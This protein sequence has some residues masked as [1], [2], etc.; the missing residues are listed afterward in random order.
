MPAIGNQER[1]LF[2]SLRDASRYAASVVNQASTPMILRVENSLFV[3]HDNRIFVFESPIENTA[4]DRNSSTST[5]EQTLI[6][7]ILTTARFR[8]LCYIYVTFRLF[9]VTA[10]AAI[11]VLLILTGEFQMPSSSDLA[12]ISTIGLEAF[13][14][15][16]LNTNKYWPLQRLSVYIGLLL[17][18]MYYVIVMYKFSSNDLSSDQYTFVIGLITLRLMAFV[19]EEVVDI[20]I[21]CYLHNVLLVTQKLKNANANGVEYKPPNEVTEDR[22]F[23]ESLLF[24]VEDLWQ[25]LR[26]TS[27]EMPPNC[28]YKG[29]FFAWGTYSVFN[30]R[31]DGYDGLQDDFFSNRSL[32]MALFI[33]SIPAFILLVCILVLVAAGAIL[34]VIAMSFFAALVTLFHTLYHACIARLPPRQGLV[35]DNT[36]KKLLNYFAELTCI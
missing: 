23:R 31:S 19:L 17:Y 3:M 24:R 8:A 32:L 6:L 35:H 29:S 15:I 27:C 28:T 11:V 14:D 25:Q 20:V 10:L 13:Y 18:V 4:I 5:P 12:L 34:A 22:S 26:L 16:I 30:V 2:E 1:R 7:N 9:D 33:P 21:D 36:L